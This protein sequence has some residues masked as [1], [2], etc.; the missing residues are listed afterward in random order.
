MSYQ[1]SLLEAIAAVEVASAIAVVV[2]GVVS[3]T[4]A[5][6]AA[7]EVV[8]AVAVLAAV[9]A[10]ETVAAGVDSATVETE[11]AL[12][13]VET[14]AALVTVEGEAA[15]VAETEA[16]DAVALVVVVA[17]GVVDEVVTVVALGAVDE[18]VTVVALGVV[19]DEDAAEAAEN[20]MKLE[21]RVWNPFRSKLAAA[22]LGGVDQIHMPPGSKVLYLGAASGTTVSHVADIV[23]PANCIDSTAEPEAVFAGEVEKLKQERLKPQEQITLEPYERDHA[24]VVGIY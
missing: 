6:E 16:A 13:T 1:A 14:E 23:G 10:L 2:V 21:Y 17:L 22:I 15:S 24:V 12:V 5:V 19:V 18:G 3:A 8:V 20:E 11:A 9:V 4:V 7:S